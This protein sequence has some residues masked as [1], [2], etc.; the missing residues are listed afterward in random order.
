M[1][2]EYT[3]LITYYTVTFHAKAYRYVY[4]YYIYYNQR[5]RGGITVSAT[6]VWSLPNKKCIIGHIGAL[7]KQL[8][9][10]PQ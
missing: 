7:T 10:L 8:Y 3:Y 4:S 2:D 5:T 1:P 9:Q 6:K